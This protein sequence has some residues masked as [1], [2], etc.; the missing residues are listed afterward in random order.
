MSARFDVALAFTPPLD[1]PALLDHFARRAVPRVEH[2][3]DGGYT[4]SL[5]LPGGPGLVSLRFAGAADPV[6]ATFTLTD[7]GDRDG[8]IALTRA[9]L[10]LDS[11]PR[12]IG[13]ALGADGLLGPVVARS[14]GRRVPGAAEATE[15]AV[16]AILGQQISLAGAAHAAGRLVHAY[17]EPLVDPDGAVT[18]LFPGAAALAGA[19]PEELR[20]PRARARSLHAVAT[21]L[22]AG[23]LGLV[24]GGDREAARARLLR[25]RASGRGRPT[26]CSCACSATT[27]C[28]WPPTSACAGRCS[29]PGCPTI[30]R[31]PRHSRSDGARIAPTRCSTCGRW[32]R[33]APARP[34]GQGSGTDSPRRR[35]SMLATTRSAIRR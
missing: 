6:D 20:M 23:D 33:P 14:P 21:A 11:D 3:G 35:R 4:R 17:G 24:R 7:P 27:T 31:P 1:V 9:L 28:S 34:P 2:V 13:A 22:A 10:D 5:R 12:A 32:G 8:A 30:P 16:R 15:L 18:H 19:D 26:T 29:A 25:C